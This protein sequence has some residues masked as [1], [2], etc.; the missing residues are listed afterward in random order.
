MSDSNI[1]ISLDEQE[2]DVLIF[3]DDYFYFSQN[4]VPYQNII[5]NL[6]TVN[7]EQSTR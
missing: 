5:V 6:P 4:C 3:P 1:R 2:E 7:F